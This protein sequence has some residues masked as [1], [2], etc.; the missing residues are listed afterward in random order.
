MFS[1]MLCDLRNQVQMSH[2]GMEIRLRPCILLKLDGKEGGL[3][4]RYLFGQSERLNKEKG[5]DSSVSGWANKRL[6]PPLFRGTKAN[7]RGR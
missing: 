7:G 5:V 3:Q 1:A 4:K 6:P 2:G